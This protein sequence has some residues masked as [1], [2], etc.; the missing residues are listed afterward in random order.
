M[1]WQLVYSNG[2]LE[3]TIM[4]LLLEQLLCAIDI[5]GATSMHAVPQQQQHAE[6]LLWQLLFAS[7][8]QGSQQ[9]DTAAV[10]AAPLHDGSHQHDAV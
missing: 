6:L 10:A 1:L 9:H 2:I 8:H 5:T 4:L 7:T 3:V